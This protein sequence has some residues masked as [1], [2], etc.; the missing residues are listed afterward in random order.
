MLEAECGGAGE[1]YGLALGLGR[2]VSGVRK[3]V[4]GRSSSGSLGRGVMSWF[5]VCKF[6][7]PSFPATFVMGTANAT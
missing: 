2:A 7:I 5:N 4:Y 6:N 1:S 3:K